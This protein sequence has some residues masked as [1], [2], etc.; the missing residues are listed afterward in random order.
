LSHVDGSTSKLA[1]D[2]VVSLIQVSASNEANR[3]PVSAIRRGCRGLD[4]CHFSDEVHSSWHIH[5]AEPADPLLWT[6]VTN[7]VAVKDEFVLGLDWIRV[8]MCAG[9]GPGTSASHATVQPVRHDPPSKDE[10]IIAVPK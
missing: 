10:M 7:P 3:P 8:T 2:C 9:H 1:S 6:L 5:R 4:T